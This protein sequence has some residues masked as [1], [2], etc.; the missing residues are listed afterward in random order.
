[1]TRAVRHFRA[2]RRGQAQA[3]VILEPE[4]EQD[5]VGLGLAHLPQR[6]IDI[7]RRG[8]HLEARLRV[9]HRREPLA[10]QPVVVDEHER[11]GG[12]PGGAVSGGLERFGDAVVRRRAPHEG[13][14]PALVPTR[15][16]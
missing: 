16:R 8:K 6:L 4:V 2:D 3:V 14:F 5:D 1:M 15:T 7:G 12:G 10:Q 11:D 9:D 13:T